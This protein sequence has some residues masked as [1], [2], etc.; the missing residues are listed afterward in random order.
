MAAIIEARGKAIKQIS[1]RFNGTQI[2]EL[3]SGLLPRGILLSQNPEIVFVESDLTEMIQQKQQLVQ[4]LIGDRPN[5][6]FLA[7]DATNSE[8]FRPL[9][10]YFQPD[11]PVTILCE[12]LLMYLTFAEKRQVFANVREI[13]QTYGGVWITSDFITKTG[14]GQ[15]RQRD[16]TL[17]QINQ[18]IV[19]STGR[20]FSENEFDDLDH[21]RQ[22]AQEQGF[23]TEEF[24]M[25]EVI[26]QLSC[27][28]ALGLD[29][30]RAQALLAATP[31]FALTY[32]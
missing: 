2:L 13:L 25:L 17:Q 22:F 29:L 3:A 8:D 28:S 12:G 23:Q 19:S 11:R 30:D 18:N 20:A 10:K 4:Q 9:N 7:I 21:A 5:L 16:P 32:C 6:H 15:L 14:A 24:S 26:N 27:L 31:V 1:L